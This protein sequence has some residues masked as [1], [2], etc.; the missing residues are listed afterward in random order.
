MTAAVADLD[1]TE[2]HGVMRGAD[3]ATV[4]DHAKRRQRDEMGTLGSGYH[5]L[6][7]QH[8]AEIFD[9]VSHSA[10]KVETRPHTS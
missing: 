5:H 9:E 4:S 10:R 1:R 8:A 7:V 3:P 6:E 2:E